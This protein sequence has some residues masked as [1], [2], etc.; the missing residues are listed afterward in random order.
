MH[1]AGY[2]TIQMVFWLNAPLLPPLID[3]SRAPRD[4]AEQRRDLD[5]R[6]RLI[7]EGPRMQVEG[8]RQRDERQ[9]QIE[10]QK[11]KGSQHQPADQRESQPRREVEH[12]R[13]SKN[14][15]NGPTI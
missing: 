7:R 15:D 14:Q 6:K 2:K 10:P 13:G 1:D 11:D 5:H 8:R 12:K 3:P 4:H 9:P